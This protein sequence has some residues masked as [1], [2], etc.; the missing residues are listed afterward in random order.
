MTLLEKQE[1]WLLRGLIME[2]DESHW[3]FGFQVDGEWEVVTSG[4]FSACVEQLPEPNS[5][6]FKYLPLQCD[7]LWNGQK[8]TKV[9]ANHAK[10]GDLKW[11]MDTNIWCEPA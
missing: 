8:W 5:T 9:T 4:E 10:R 1:F 7:F 6:R 2:N 11:P 3:E